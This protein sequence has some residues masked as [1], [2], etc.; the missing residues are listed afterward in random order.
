MMP[1][2]RRAAWL[3]YAVR[4]LESGKE[5]G[6]EG[7]KTGHEVD[8]LGCWLCYYLLIWGVDM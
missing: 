1:Q 8:F 7:F 2:I 6:A 5:L 4:S 3:M